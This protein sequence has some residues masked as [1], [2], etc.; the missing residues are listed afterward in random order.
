MALFKG[1]NFHI[2]SVTV[3]TKNTKMRKWL[4]TTLKLLIWCLEALFYT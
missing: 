3:H 1:K 4:R 2:H